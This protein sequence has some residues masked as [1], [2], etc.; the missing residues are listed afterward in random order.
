MGKS[1]SCGET[2]RQSL[3]DTEGVTDGSKAPPERPYKTRRVL[4]FP[5][6]DGVTSVE[7]R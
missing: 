1:Y 5:C 6:T 4:E 3:R 2:E 7:K